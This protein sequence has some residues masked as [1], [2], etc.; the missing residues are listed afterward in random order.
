LERGFLNAFVKLK[1]MRMT[2]ANA[3]PN[4]FNNAFRRKS[5]DFFN[6]Q[7]KRAKLDRFQFFTQRKID[8]LGD[9]GEKTERKMDLVTGNPVHTANAWVESDQDF[10]NG[11]RWID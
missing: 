1:Q 3:E 6:G 2:G 8:L 5:P 11:W 10:P 7:K 9:V 4:Y